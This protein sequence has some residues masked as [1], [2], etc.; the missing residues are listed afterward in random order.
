M[1][2]LNQ[3]FDDRRLMRVLVAPVGNNSRFGEQYQVV[4]SLAEIPYYELN[5]PQYPKN[6]VSPF[7][8][9][10]WKDGCL[11]FQYSRYDRA[12]LGDLDD[13]QVSAPQ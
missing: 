3:T 13:F 11:V 6:Y 7:K 10:N 8:F 5:R 1:L 12:S 4:S 9:L 2:S